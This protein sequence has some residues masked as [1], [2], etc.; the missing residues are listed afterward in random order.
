MHYSSLLV[1]WP[2]Q[3]Q[4]FAHECVNER[5]PNTGDAQQLRAVAQSG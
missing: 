2:L 3:V 4:S 5:E 1:C